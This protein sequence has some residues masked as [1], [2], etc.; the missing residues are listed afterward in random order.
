MVQ[1][2]V[3]NL[4]DSGAGS[5]RQAI[6]DA[7]N[8]PGKDEIIFDEGLSGGEITL[9]SGQ[10]EITDSLTVRGLGADR[11]TLRGNTE[12]TAFDNR[13]F[14]ISDGFDNQDTFFDVELIGLTITEGLS[15][16]PRFSG[17]GGAIDNEENLT[18]ID[19]IITDNSAPTGGGI[20]NRGTLNVK[21][22]AIINNTADSVFG[23]LDGGGISNSGTAV[24]ENSTIANNYATTGGG[25]LNGNGAVLE[26]FNS[27]ITGN[28]TRTNTIYDVSG[29][30]Y[31]PDETQ[32]SNSRS[33]AGI[34]N[35][36][37]TRTQFPGQAGQ[38]TVTIT[39][40][41]VAGNA[42]NSDLGGNL[43]DDTAPPAPF[44]SGG[45]NLIGIG[46]TVSGFTD[47]VNGDIVGT[48]DAPIDPRLSTLQNNGGKT[49]TAALLSDSPAIDAGSNPNN[50]EFDQRGSGFNRVVNGSADIGAFEVQNSANLVRIVATT[51]TAI[52]GGENGIFTI[53]RTGD[54]SDEL[55]VNLNLANSSTAN[56]DEYSFS[57]SN[58]SITDNRLTVTI[59]A[60]QSSVDLAVSAVDDTLAEE[61]EII[62]LDLAGGGSYGIDSGN[63]AATVEIARSDFDTGT[64][65]TNTNDAGAGSLRQAIIIANAVEGTDTITFDPSLSGET[66]TLT[67]GELAI[68]DSVDIKGLGAEQ[69]AVSGNNNSRVFNIDDGNNSLIDV[70]IE[71]LTI[72]DGNDG[73]I[74]NQENSTISNSVITG[75]TSNSFGI[76]GIE[77]ARDGATLLLKN[78]TVTGNY[79]SYSGGISNGSNS[80]LIIE[81]STIANNESEYNAGGIYSAGGNLIIKNST[82][83]NNSVSENFFSNITGGIKSF[84]TATIISTTVSDNLNGGIYASN[85]EI[86]NSTVS[87]NTSNLDNSAAGI[88]VEGNS[89]IRNSTISNNVNN[90]SASYRSDYGV[91][92][93]VT[94]SGNLEII[95]STITGNS[96]ESNGG[97]VNT[98]YGNLKIIESIISDNTAR[99]GSGG[100]VTNSFF[101]DLEVVQSTVSGNNTAANGGGI[102]NTNYSNLEI[103]Q[104]TISD[105]SANNGGGIFNYGDGFAAGPGN[106]AISNSTITNNSAESGSGITNNRNPIKVTSTIIAQNE[107]SRDLAGISS[108]ISNGNNLIGNGDGAS[109]FVNNE[110]NDL[111][112]TSGNAIDP[113]L[114]TLQD[115]GGATPTIA[116]LDGSRA[117]DA[118]SNPLELTTD[119]RGESFPR[120]EDGD[121]DSVA[122]TDIGAFEAN[123]GTNPNPPDSG[124][125]G[126][127]NNGEIIVGTDGGDSL[128][129]G[130]GNDTIDG[131]LNNDTLFGDAGNDELFGG[132]GR[133]SLVGN[134]GSDT[135]RG[136]NGSDSLNGSAGDDE[137]FGDSGSDFL[138]G[139]SGNDF[140]DSGNGSDTLVGGLGEDRFVIALQQGVDNIIDYSYGT[141]TLV[142]GD[143]L[144]F[145]Q[146]NLVE[147]NNSTEIRL[148]DGDRLLT[149]LNSVSPEEIDE[150]DFV[151]S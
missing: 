56:T 72:Q 106:T 92:G 125:N 123:A 144:S 79:G 45:N 66:I 146:L 109:G 104:S 23:P 122:V 126:N 151:T 47:G 119:Q 61:V 110:N 10:L 6:E 143:G 53:S 44:N 25:I 43:S 63:S 70:A 31:L 102:Y 36:Y 115:N 141:D 42:N 98:D 90:Y 94:N 38:G 21:N 87:G 17:R 71:G 4:E 69:I 80:N 129:G 78:S 26:V 62:V 39:S 131:G 93:G 57:G 54:T 100:G 9:A 140:I 5:L 59:P 51:P 112:G 76:G 65:V 82:I 16:G 67:S 150:S 20:Q 49:L 116:L 128:F 84:G 101:S 64:V 27:T 3:T 34:Y 89:V 48:T 30:E 91:S 130:V 75:N 95:Q 58:V 22:S 142:L 111:V 12:T 60:G 85:L 137:L 74:L 33:G 52:E 118:G 99:S 121:N 29:Q 97:I 127:N 145:G 139:G 107:G 148:S 28:I 113:L 73:G 7:N 68:A 40:S 149:T 103:I 8:Q 46:D 147:K 114:G 105:N 1:F 41:I 81:N 50:L 124:G 13:I 108:F 86:I 35:R 133:D 2:I 55:I 135:L 77:N 96:A 14:A 88:N 15:F 37:D 117:I 11:I 134:D 138:V 24:I 18:I 83:S 136:G 32:R 19:S 120:T 132:E